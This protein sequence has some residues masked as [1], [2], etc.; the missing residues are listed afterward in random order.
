M[1]LGFTISP[2]RARMWHFKAPKTLRFKGT[3]ANFETTNAIKQGKK[4]QKD[5]WYPFHACT[6]GLSEPVMEFPAILGLFLT[7]SM[8]GKT[9]ARGSLMLLVW[10][11]LSLAGRMNGT[12]PPESNSN[13]RTIQSASHMIKEQTKFGPKKVFPRICLPKL[14]SSGELFGVNSYQIPSF[15]E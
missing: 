15:C 5:K 7:C 8:K 9:R 13:L 10:Q 12:S 3:M 4:R 1:V 2:F 6:E 11:C 14:R